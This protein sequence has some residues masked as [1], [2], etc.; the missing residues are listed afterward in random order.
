MLDKKF[1][2]FNNFIFD[3]DGTIWWWNT[4]VPGA[5]KVIDNLRAAGK[6]VYFITNNCA[7]PRSGYAR[8]LKKFGI[9]ANTNMI[10]NPSIVA[11]GL[12]EGKKVFVIGE[13]I[14]HDLRAGKA[15]LVK[16]KAEAVLIAEDRK[17]N[18]EKLTRASEL[19]SKGA[20]GYK[21]A[22]G[23][24]WVMGKEK[25]IP[26]TGAIAA[27]IETSTRENLT[28][29]GKPSDYM[30]DLI[31]ALK[32]KADKTLMTGDTLASDIMMGNELKFSTALVL[33]GTDSMENY[34]KAKKEET[35]D[36]ILKSIAD[37]IKK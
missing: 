6:T 21:T 36:F 28:L 22:S 19:I 3:L 5:G 17:L 13:G 4:L 29:L 8:K 10:L 37:L 1:E 26:G 18:F 9:K 34:K 30:I 24:I 16:E 25:R 27:A 20:K 15:K 7:L 33:T 31:K 23:G 2:K 12:L 32:L 11:A 14:R 35:P